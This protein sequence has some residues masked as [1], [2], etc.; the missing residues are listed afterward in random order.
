MI[1]SHLMYCSLVALGRW[2]INKKLNHGTHGQLVSS[3]VR[4]SWKLDF[5]SVRIFSVN[6]LHCLP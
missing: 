5:H 3:N 2:R 1:R 4:V 6:C